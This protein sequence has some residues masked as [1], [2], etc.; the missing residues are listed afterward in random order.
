M[1]TKTKQEKQ[2]PLVLEQP[3]PALVEGPKLSYSKINCLS[4]CK[5]QYKYSYIDKLPRVQSPGA[6]VG[7]YCHTVLEHF[8][9]HYNRSETFSKYACMTKAFQEAQVPFDIRDEVKE[10]VLKWMEYKTLDFPSL[11]GTEVKIIVDNN[12]KGKVVNDIEWQEKREFFFRCII[13]RLHFCDGNVFIHDYKT[14][15]I[16]QAD[17]L[18]LFLYAWAIWKTFPIN[19][20]TC[21]FEFIRFWKTEDQKTITLIHLMEA[22]KDLIEIAKTLQSLNVFQ[23]TLG[24]HCQW[25][26]YLNLCE[27]AKQLKFDAIDPIELGNYVTITEAKLKQAK[28]KLKNYIEYNGPVDMGDQTQW[29]IETGESEVFDDPEKFRQVHAKYYGT[30]KESRLKPFS[31]YYKPPSI[32]NTK[33]GAKFLRN[34]PEF[35]QILVKKAKYPQLKRE[36]LT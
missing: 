16:P 8:V 28:A 22:E 1:K 32:D 26:P 19:Q 14:N 3:S 27:E 5:K 30:G 17:F 20:A 25:C 24:D 2:M 10:I 9:N 15:R 36:K 35:Q 6:M 18:Q 11:Y 33:A 21:T 34:I 7:S 23:A 4:T 12:L 13:D 31:Y 29:T